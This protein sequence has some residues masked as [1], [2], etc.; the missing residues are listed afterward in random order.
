[1]HN[2]P[3]NDE[4]YIFTI[5]LTILIY[6]KEEQLYAPQYCASVMYTSDKQNDCVY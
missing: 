5:I 6:Q 3:N 1:M 2:K 4:Q